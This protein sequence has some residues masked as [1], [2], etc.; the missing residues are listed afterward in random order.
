[1]FCILPVSENLCSPPFCTCLNSVARSLGQDTFKSTTYN[2]VSSKLY[3]P[4]YSLCKI[5]GNGFKVSGRR[6]LKCM[7]ALFC[8]S[9]N[10]QTNELPF[11]KMSFPSS[12]GMRESNDVTWMSVGCDSLLFKGQRSFRF[13]TFLTGK[14]PAL[15]LAVWMDQ[16]MVRP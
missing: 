1:M 3:T 14:D 15:C 8:R 13:G 16:K 4:F 10:S 2:S 9:T 12:K 7:G 5:E 6:L 11:H